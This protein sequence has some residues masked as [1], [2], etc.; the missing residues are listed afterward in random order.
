L[1]VVLLLSI[2]ARRLDPVFAISIGLAAAFTRINRE[3]K[4]KGRSTQESLDVFRRRWDLAWASKEG[5]KGTG[6]V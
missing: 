1:V 2:F 3:E 4:E 6:K 5:E